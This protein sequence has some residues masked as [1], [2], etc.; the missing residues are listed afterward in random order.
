MVSFYYFFLYKDGFTSAKA[1][2][3]QLVGLLNLTYYYHYYDNGN[4]ND[5]KIFFFSKKWPTS[6][7]S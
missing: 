3:S 5:S 1:P 6:E 4:N 7:V 2:R